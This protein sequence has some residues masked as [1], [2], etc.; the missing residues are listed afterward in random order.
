MLITGRSS[1][2]GLDLDARIDLDVLPDAE[3][4]ALLA[5]MIG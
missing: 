4:V 2:T 3:A 5:Q 1:P